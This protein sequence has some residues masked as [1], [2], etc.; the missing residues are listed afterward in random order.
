MSSEYQNPDGPPHPSGDA[1]LICQ[2]H[3]LIDC[4]FH[5]AETWCKRRVL[6]LE[7]LEERRGEWSVNVDFIMPT[8]LCYL[9]VLQ[10]PD[11]RFALPL[12]TFSKDFMPPAHITTEDE[13]HH[14]VPLVSSHHSRLVAFAIALAAADSGGIPTTGVCRN[15]LWALRDANTIL[16]DLAWL[17]LQSHIPVGVPQCEAPTRDEFVLLVR[18]LARSALICLEFKTK[19]RG[20][21]KLVRFSHDGPI[22]IT[23]KWIEV[24]GLYPRVICTRAVFGGNAESYHVQIVPPERVTVVDSRLLYS[25][26]GYRT[27]PRIFYYERQDT[28]LLQAE[29]L[30]SQTSITTAIAQDGASQWWGYVEGPA[31]PM[32]AHVRCPS[33]RM[34][35]LEEGRDSFAL[36]RFYPQFAGLLSLI[37]VAAIVNVAFVI[38]YVLG[39]RSGNEL[40][41]FVPAHPEAVLMLVGIV[42]GLGV[43]LTLYPKEHLLTSSVLRPWRRLEALLAGFTIAVPITSLWGWKNTRKPQLSGVVYGPTLTIEMWL[44][45]ITFLF[46]VGI[47][48][49]PWYS[50]TSGG[51]RWRRKGVLLRR[52]QFPRVK[53]H[54]RGR[55]LD[56]LE[57]AQRLHDASGRAWG[58]KARVLE[59]KKT[60]KVRRWAREYLVEGRRAELFVRGIPP[61]VRHERDARA[62][63]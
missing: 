22:R 8:A 44:D 54:R 21:R 20:H 35:R 43:T 36:F 11:K 59:R 46:L 26:F 48:V 60:Q 15:F 9:P 4:L 19:E 49:V 62:G 27:N 42:A 53:W 40:G 2:G 1:A 13:G 12:L 10:L 41:N 14:R 17:E 33:R 3:Q 23:R 57:I 18:L 38:A 55:T 52:S 31:E 47:T 56:D 5:N 29:E 16:S 39:I 25:Y 58:Q 50:E 24:L 7:F 63:R 30:L 32:S 51:D 34:P 61:A 45:I 37:L 6:L 28:V